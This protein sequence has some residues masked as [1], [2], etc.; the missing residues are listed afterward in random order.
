MATASPLPAR[1][2]R[3][4]LK[5]VRLPHRAQ[6]VIRPDLEPRFSPTGGVGRAEKANLAPQGAIVKG[7]PGMGAALQFTGPGALLRL[8]GGRVRPRCKKRDYKIGGRDR[9]PLRRRLR[10][11][12][13]YAPRCFVD[14]R[15]TGRFRGSA[16]R[17]V[18]L[19]TDGPLFSGASHGFCIGHVG[20]EAAVGRGRFALLRDDGD[21]GVPRFDDAVRRHD[22]PS[23][24]AMAELAGTAP[25]LGPRGANDYQSGHAVENMRKQS[26]DAEKGGG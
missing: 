24:S 17:R 12:S 2:L 13:R 1:R 11:G 5:N 21:V 7:R 6:N 8:R 4:N 16:R 19:I 15:C 20:P 22:R 23:R 18:A 25:S 14:D 9:D 3:K 10:G 26:V